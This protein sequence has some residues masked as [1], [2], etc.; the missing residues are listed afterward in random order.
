MSAVTARRVTGDEP[1]A[2][3]ELVSP[4]VGLAVGVV[5]TDVGVEPEL[6]APEVGFGGVAFP[7]P[8]AGQG[9]RQGSNTRNGDF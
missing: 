7:P 2:G 4:S 9:K 3:A 6:D 1:G 8:T 5:E